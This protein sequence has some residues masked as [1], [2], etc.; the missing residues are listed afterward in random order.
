MSARTPAGRVDISENA[1]VSQQT[2]SDL[3]IDILNPT[4]YNDSLLICPFV[5]R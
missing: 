2:N 1:R 5:D 4:F 3:P